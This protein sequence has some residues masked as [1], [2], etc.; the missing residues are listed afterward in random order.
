MKKVMLYLLV[1]AAIASG[2]NSARAQSNQIQPINHALDQ[3]LINVVRDGRTDKV[4]KGDADKIASLLSQGA[5]PNAKD[6]SASALVWALNFGKDDA[7]TLLIEHGADGGVEDSEGRNAAW[8][9]AGIYFCPKALELMIHK[10]VDVKGL[11]KKGDTIFSSMT[12]AVPAVRG[13]M[14]YLRDRVW[15]DAEFDAYQERERRTVD[16]LLA[17]GVDING[18]SGPKAQTPLMLA[19]QYGHLIMAGELIEKG[20]D[21]SLKDSSG[22]TAT[23]YAKMFGHLELIRLLEAK[24]K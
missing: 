3:T 13:K 24:S 15:T 21:V 16:L 9:A 5:D 12:A 8:T 6:T 1:L 11:D 2:P 19:A 10:G 17:A 14:N 18:R 4:G 22:Q 23:T 7:A 20:A